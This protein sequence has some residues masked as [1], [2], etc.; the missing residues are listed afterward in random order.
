MKNHP[1]KKK[2]KNGHPTYSY[3]QWSV[4]SQKKKK[5]KLTTPKF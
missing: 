5:K 3:G 1:K 2:K 4:V